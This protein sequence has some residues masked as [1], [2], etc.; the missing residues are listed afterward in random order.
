MAL[1]AIGMLMD[2]MLG[3]PK[4]KREVAYYTKANFSF[5]FLGTQGMAQVKL[6][7]EWGERN[8]GPR[9]IEVIKLK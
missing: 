1:G 6:P 3:N 8:E 2:H 5:K 4:P 9:T 7:L